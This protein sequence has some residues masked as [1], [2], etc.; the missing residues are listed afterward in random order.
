MLQRRSR[1]FQS[2]EC[3]P[4]ILVARVNP[5]LPPVIHNFYPLV[6]FSR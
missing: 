4:F 3:Y 5:M 2:I 6:R 1:I